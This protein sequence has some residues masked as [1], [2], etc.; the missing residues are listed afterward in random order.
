MSDEAKWEQYEYFLAE[1]FACPCCG[2]AEMKH[3]FMRELEALRLWL[4]EPMIINSGYRCPAHNETVVGSKSSKHMEGIAADVKTYN[5][6]HQRRILDHALPS[7]AGV[8]IA[9]TF[10]HLDTRSGAET[11][12]T[13]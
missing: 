2:K 3:S 13:Y 4:D 1:E 9:K 6:R 5:G 8:G 11:I 12:W 7:F 10:V